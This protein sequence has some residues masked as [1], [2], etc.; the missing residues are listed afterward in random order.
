MGW[1]VWGWFEVIWGGWGGGSGG[2]E[3]RRGVGG[4]R[5]RC[6]QL[7]ASIQTKDRSFHTPHY[8]TPHHT[9]ATTT[10]ATT[11]TITTTTT[12]TT[13]IRE[14]NDEQVEVE[15][16][17]PGLRGTPARQSMPR[18]RGSGTPA[19]RPTRLPPVC[20]GWFVLGG[21]VGCLVCVWVCVW[22]GG[23]DQLGGRM[24]M[25]AGVDQSVCV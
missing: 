8:T 15:G 23:I 24:S 16:V 1:S 3:G 5:E 9:K 12:T 11:T 25:W 7:H 21:W 18:W 10:K 20:V 13:T 2:G 19:V 6:T 17:A 22:G 4:G 14:G